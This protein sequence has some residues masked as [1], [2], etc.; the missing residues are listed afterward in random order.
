MNLLT[1]NQVSEQIIKKKVKTKHLLIGNGFSMAYDKKIFSYDA[2]SKF[3]EDTQI[4]MLKKMFKITNTRNFEQIMKQ[5]DVTVKI[6]EEFKGD[7]ALIENVVS[8]G[9]TLKESLID[10]IEKLHPAH[11]FEIAEGESKMCAIFIKDYLD[12]LGK[13]FSTNYDIL[14]YWVLMRHMKDNFFSCNDG[15]G[16]DKLDEDGKITAQEKRPELYWG[17]NKEGQNVFYLHGALPLFNNG[18]WI[19][20]ATY[21][22]KKVIL[23]NIKERINKGGYPIFVAGGDSEDKLYQILHNPYLSFC[24]DKLSTIDGSLV[25]FGFNF[26]ENDQHIIDAINEASKALMST[27]LSSIYIGVYSEEDRA[28]IETI[29]HKFKFQDVNMFDASTVRIWR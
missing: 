8:M 3:I 20:K 29:K 23:E 18:A 17:K 12:T 6:I 2:L 22:G 4:D 19:T 25:T 10:A 21:D 9:I 24:Y 5:L 15:F 7:K 26:G 16:R 13:V 1:Y 27:R 11:V 28:H 14:L